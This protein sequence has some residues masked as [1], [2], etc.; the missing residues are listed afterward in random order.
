MYKLSSEYYRIFKSI[1]Y[2]VRTSQIDSILNWIDLF[3]KV[4]TKDEAKRLKKI[5][6]NKLIILTNTF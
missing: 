6:F 5:A 4:S 2:S 3:E 1:K